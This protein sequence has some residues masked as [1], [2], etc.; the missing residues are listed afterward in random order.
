VRRLDWF[1]G[2]LLTWLL[3]FL[4]LITF[5]QHK[6]PRY[7]FF[8]YFPI[9]M[10]AGFGVDQMV[11]T[12][13][14]TAVPSLVAAGCGLFLLVGAYLQPTPCGPDYGDLVSNQ[15]DK[16]RGHIVFVEGRRDGDFIFAVRER[17]GPRQAVIV[18]GSKLLY[19]CAADTRWRYVSH[20][21]DSDDLAETLNKFGFSA[22][23]VERENV[24]NVGEAGLLMDYLSATPTYTRV[25]T[26]VLSPVRMGQKGVSR[27]VDMYVPQQPLERSVRFMVI[28]MPIASQSIRVDLDKLTAELANIAREG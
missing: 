19:S 23:F 11:C 28:P 13:R 14:R 18:R 20:I 6:Q 21:A 8:A 16:I 26:Q 25:A 12:F 22:L 27:T 1:N 5:I 7:L 9:A 2:Y 3:G 24:T 10:W 17:L 4:L 15:A